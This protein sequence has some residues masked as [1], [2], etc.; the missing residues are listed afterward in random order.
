M[1]LSSK[2]VKE[3]KE[4][5][6]FLIW[7]FSS[8]EKKNRYQSGHVWLESIKLFTANVPPTASSFCE[9]LLLKEPKKN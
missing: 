1:K 9:D 6:C 3:P 4:Q 2:N 8:S 7:R 5:L